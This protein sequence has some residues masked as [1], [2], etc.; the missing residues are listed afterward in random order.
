LVSGEGE[1]RAVPRVDAAPVQVHDRRVELRIFTYDHFRLEVRE[2]S[3]TS[4]ITRGMEAYSRPRP[5]VTQKV[6]QRS[7]YETNKFV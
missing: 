2:L 6:S 4:I 1:V 3:E 7:G 5:P